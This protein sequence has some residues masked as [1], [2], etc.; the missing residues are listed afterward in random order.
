MKKLKLGSKVLYRGKI[1]TLLGYTRSGTSCVI[2]GPEGKHSGDVLKYWHD[3]Y[4]KPVAY[5]NKNWENNRIFVTVAETIPCEQ[6]E[7]EFIFNL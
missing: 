5:T 2:E 1:H 4:G 6:S 7:P 3:E